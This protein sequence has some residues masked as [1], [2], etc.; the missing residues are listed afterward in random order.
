MNACA[1]VTSEDN[2]YT[3]LNCLQIHDPFI[4]KCEFRRLA[5]DT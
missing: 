4:P 5:G 2:F 3:G 1:N